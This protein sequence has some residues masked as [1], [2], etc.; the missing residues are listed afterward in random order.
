VIQIQRVQPGE[1]QG[2]HILIMPDITPEETDSAQKL[3]ESIALAARNG[4]SFDSLQKVHHDKPEEREAKEVP[5]TKLPPAYAKAIGDSPRGTV[6]TPFVLEGTSGR[7][8]FAVVMVTERREAGEV[9][10][11]DVRDK[12]RDQ[13]GE[14]LAIR[15][16]LDRLKKR[17]YVEVRM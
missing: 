3:A 11:E 6:L 15:R 17:T 2:R 12:V 4:A 14:Q 9:R 10:F 8:K 7:S 13:L 16:Y 5:V 1:V